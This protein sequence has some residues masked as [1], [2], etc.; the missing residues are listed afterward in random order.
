MDYWRGNKVGLVRMVT[1]KSR[2]MGL[3]RGYFQK[4]APA[5]KSPSSGG[6]ILSYNFG[7]N[8][9]LIYCAYVL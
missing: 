5:N 8:L 7:C 6:V 1:P 2:E 9:C 4:L 3:R